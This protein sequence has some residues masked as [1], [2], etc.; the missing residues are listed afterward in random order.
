MRLAERK[1]KLLPQRPKAAHFF[2]E[3]KSGF[4]SGSIL[5]RKKGHLQNSRPHFGQ[6]S[7]GSPKGSVYRWSRRSYV[8]ATTAFDLR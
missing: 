8:L 6:K 5:A 4:P 2:V 3:K 1:L 7:E